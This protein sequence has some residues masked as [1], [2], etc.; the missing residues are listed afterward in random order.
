MACRECIYM[1]RANYKARNMPLPFVHRW[2]AGSLGGDGGQGRAWPDSA[3]SQ[4]EQVSVEDKEVGQRGTWQSTC[5]RER[6]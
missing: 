2:A 5:S 4:R 1:V 6:V 3:G